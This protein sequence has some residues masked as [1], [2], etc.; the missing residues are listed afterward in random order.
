MHEKMKKFMY[1]DDVSKKHAIDLNDSASF[2]WFF[3]IYVNEEK[4][5]S[6]DCDCDCDCN[7]YILVTLI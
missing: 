1:D 3:F 7:S 6:S 5:R 2:E 4:V